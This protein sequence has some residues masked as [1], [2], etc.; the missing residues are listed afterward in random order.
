MK[1]KLGLLLT[2]T[3]A[4]LFIATTAQASVYTVQP[5]DYLWK[6][7]STQKTTVEKIM[8]LNKL[9][10]TSLYP[11]QVLQLPDDPNSYIVQ[12]SDTFW[13]IAMRFGIGVDTLILANPQISNPNNIWPGLA[14]HIPQKP[15]A[16]LDGTFPLAKGTYEQFWNNYAD[17]R[18][19]SSSGTAVRSHEGVDIFA[20]KGTP[21]YSVLD[22]TITNIGWSELG[23]W[24]ITIKVD[25][26][27]SFYYAHLSGYAGSM[28]KG[29]TV[30][31]GQ[32]LGYVGNTGYGP[33]GTEGKFDSHLHFGMYQNNPWQAIDP[34]RYLNWW[35]LNAK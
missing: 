14:I 27:T 4:S 33:V 15:A 18:A 26:N 31:K 16:F 23:G 32:M 10:S 25:A 9:S 6:I 24:R 34:Y 21:V 5:G 35:Q 13:K 29:D 19:W 30:R 2:S 28:K 12:N 17:A 20:K 1:K 3:V 11:G 7:A 22:G 8:E